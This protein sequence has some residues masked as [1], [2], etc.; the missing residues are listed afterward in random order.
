[1]SRPLCH[2]L[3]SAVALGL[4][5]S[6]AACD[7]TEEEQPEEPV[8]STTSDTVDSPPSWEAESDPQARLRGC[9]QGA[10]LLDRDVWAAGIAK[11]LEDSDFT[12][13]DVKGSGVIR[14]DMA[15]DGT[16]VLTATD[17]ETTSTGSGPG[18]DLRWVMSF[19]GTEAG[20]WSASADTLVLTAGAGGR[21]AA[22]NQISFDGQPIPATGL[23]VS[24][25]PWSETLNV[26]CDAEKLS[27][28]PADD[29]AAPEIVLRRVEN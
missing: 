19:D 13:V 28:A 14:F 3:S 27:A 25:T 23:P 12:G 9:L 5:L 20:T 6:L 2:L 29:P 18:G 8:S 15:D 21:L 22:D 26:A 1:M 24:G 7:G 17:S 10:F 11:V 4:L 16:Y